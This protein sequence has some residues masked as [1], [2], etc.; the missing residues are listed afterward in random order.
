M[1]KF[2]EN[3]KF[4]KCNLYFHKGHIWSDDLKVESDCSFIEIKSQKL[5]MWPLL[6]ILIKSWIKNG[7]KSRST[8]GVIITKENIKSN[9]K[10]LRF[11]LIKYTKFCSLVY[12]VC[13]LVYINRHRKVSKNRV[14]NTS[15]FI[16]KYM[17]GQ[18]YKWKWP[19]IDNIVHGEISYREI[20]FDVIWIKL[21]LYDAFSNKRSTVHF[22][23]V[24]NS[25]MGHIIWAIY[26]DHIYKHSEC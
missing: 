24:K 17:L 4:E 19:C 1:R 20:C 25:N 7:T 22:I 2:K 6:H 12:I 9:S 26:I 23:D 15:F 11:M 3:W 10:Y 8:L 16:S 5:K 13:S 14:E 21:N 18:T